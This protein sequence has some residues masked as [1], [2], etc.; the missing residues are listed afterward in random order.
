MGCQTDLPADGD[1]QRSGARWSEPCRPLWAFLAA[2]RAVALG[3]AFTV[4]ILTVDVRLH[5]YQLYNNN[6]LWP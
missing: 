4:M 5:Y 3:A 2:Q 6:M 1:S